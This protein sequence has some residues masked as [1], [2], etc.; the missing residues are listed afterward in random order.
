MGSNLVAVVFGVKEL[1]V[2]HLFTSGGSKPFS[3]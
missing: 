1:N 2:P 3:Y